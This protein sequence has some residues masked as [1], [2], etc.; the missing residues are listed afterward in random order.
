[1]FMY[2]LKGAAAS[3][4]AAARETHQVGTNTDCDFVA[5]NRIAAYVVGLSDYRIVRCDHQGI[6]L[7]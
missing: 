5:M 2:S 3:L 6:Q 4:D 7:G 1:M